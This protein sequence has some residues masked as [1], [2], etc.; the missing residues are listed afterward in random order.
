M[1]LPPD[2]GF[3]FPQL[4][5]S[6]VNHHHPG[7]NVTTS[8]LSLVSQLKVCKASGQDVLLPARRKLRKCDC[9]RAFRSSR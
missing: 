8:K 1:I 2:R 4:Q 5:A 6:F 9:D 3:S 7:L